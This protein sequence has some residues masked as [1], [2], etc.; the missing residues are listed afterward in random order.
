MLSNVLNDKLVATH[1][2]MVVKKA[3]EDDLFT[4]SG[5]DCK[6]TGAVDQ[7]GGGTVTCPECELVSCLKCSKPVHPGLLCEEVV[8]GDKEA[9]AEKEMRE[10]G[11]LQCPSCKVFREKDGGC[12]KMTCDQCQTHWCAECHELIPEAVSY[13]HFTPEGC[14]MYPNNP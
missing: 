6:Y 10:G 9:N 14:Q 4:C 5:A 1:A 2:Q 8:Q 12:N 3:L 13:N 7:G 11:Y